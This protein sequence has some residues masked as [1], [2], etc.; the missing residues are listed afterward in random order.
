MTRVLR[1]HTPHRRIRFRHALG[2]GAIYLAV[3]V[4]AK[5]WAH[6]PSASSSA[7]NG[8]SL[9]SMS[10][11]ERASNQLFSLSLGYIVSRQGAQLPSS[12]A[13]VLK[14]FG[15]VHNHSLTLSF[16]YA[17]DPW[18]LAISLPVGVSLRSQ[19]GLA[20][21]SVWGLGD[22]RLSG[23]RRFILSRR[24]T[25]S[26]RSLRL[27][28]Q[29][30][31]VM[32]TGRYRREDFVEASYLEPNA[33]DGAF[34]VRR[35]RAQPGLGAGVWSG[36]LTLSLG[37][38][39][40]RQSG[41]TAVLQGCLPMSRTKEGQRWGPDVQ[42]QLLAD[43]SGPGRAIFAFLGPDVLYHGKDRWSV[44]PTKEGVNAGVLDL[45]QSRRQRWGVRVGAGA[46]VST[47]LSCSLEAVVALWQRAEP[48]ALRESVQGLASCQ[49]SFGPPAQK[50]RL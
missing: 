7:A 25:P 15:R 36:L 38:R 41:W 40:H 37:Q 3:G 17:P 12:N 11:L 2:V 49:W 13:K 10:A 42:A 43:V 39:W 45:E 30:G 14:A 1:T 46:R 21:S 6:H 8:A 34:A 4:G 27:L 35:V 16:R 33:Q 44:T 22:L 9:N 29:A 50:G 26:P 5:A 47:S 23:G 32:P 19:E 31:L 48:G 20:K 24:D 18:N 28:V